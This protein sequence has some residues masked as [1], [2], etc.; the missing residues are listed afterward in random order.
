MSQALWGLRSK[1]S[2]VKITKTQNTIKTVYTEATPHLST[3]ITVIPLGLIKEHFPRHP[4]GPLSSIPDVVME[5]NCQ[6]A[7]FAALKVGWTHF[8]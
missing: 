6:V 2:H 5:M 1:L 4:D 7:N 8:D 3:T